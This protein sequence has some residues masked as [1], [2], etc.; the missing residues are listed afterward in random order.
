[1]DRRAVAKTAKVGRKGRAA[2]CA[3][4]RPKPVSGDVAERILEQMDATLGKWERR[5]YCP[6]CVAR[7][8]LLSSGLL[9]A[10]ELQA[11][12]HARGAWLYR[13][14]ERE[15]RTTIRQHGSALGRR[16]SYPA[17]HAPNKTT[18]SHARRQG[19]AGNADLQ[20]QRVEDCASTGDA[21]CRIYLPG[22][23]LHRGADWSWLLSRP[24][25]AT[26]EKAWSLAYEPAN[27]QALCPSHHSIET[28][29][30]IAEAKGKPERSGCD[31]RGW[32]TSRSHPW[33]RN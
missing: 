6:C 1:M 12:R 25:Q 31:E 33:F 7:I 17:R 16:W 2:T 9:A 20:L 13:H 10:P 11:R 23:R 8:L 3:I 21:C 29:K 28:N 4:I 26:A 5:G 32:P 27:H 22:S 30:E 18:R 14:A 24:S 19:H 15:T